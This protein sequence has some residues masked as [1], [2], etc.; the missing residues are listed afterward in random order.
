MP[1]MS[2]W[3]DPAPAGGPPAVQPD[4]ATATRGEG[5]SVRHREQSQRQGRG[6]ARH[7]PRFISR[8]RPA[9][10][11]TPRTDAPAAGLTGRHCSRLIILRN[12]GDGRAPMAGRAA[13]GDKYPAISDD[14]R[15]GEGAW[16]SQS[17]WRTVM[18]DSYGARGTHASTGA[19]WL[20]D[21]RDN[22]REIPFGSASKHRKLL[23]APC[24]HVLLSK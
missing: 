18:A 16:S 15:N 11:R 10:R 9:P 8:W 3:A 19:D 12:G 14:G 23:S 2:L 22:G 13:D 1:T 4:P 5:S 7:A 6:T 24:R 17:V 20:T 21:L